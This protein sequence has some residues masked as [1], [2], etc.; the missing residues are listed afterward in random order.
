MEPNLSI[1]FGFTSEADATPRPTLHIRITAGGGFVSA[2][3]GEHT[4]TFW[5][6][7]AEGQPRN[8]LSSGWI[9]MLTMNLTIADG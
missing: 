5:L 3:D 1:G 8:I 2:I 7:W 4:A 9:T 6:T